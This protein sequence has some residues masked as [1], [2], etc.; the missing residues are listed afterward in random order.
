MC[1]DKVDL[2]RTNMTG[3]TSREYWSSS[4][5]LKETELPTGC[6]S[7]FFFF[8][9]WISEAISWTPAVSSNTID[10]G[11]KSKFYLYHT[12]CTSVLS[13]I[14][15]ACKG[16]RA[17][18]KMTSR[19]QALLIWNRDIPLSN[20]KS[21]WMDFPQSSDVFYLFRWALDIVLEHNWPRKNYCKK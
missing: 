15:L 5:C 7:F 13:L 20:K 3:H 12:H 9:Q 17:T 16:R 11:P 19:G 21:M 18:L 14:W 1:W 8:G 10:T 4:S 2:V 6:W